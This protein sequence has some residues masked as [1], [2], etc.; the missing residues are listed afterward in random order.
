MNQ[1]GFNLILLIIIIAVVVIGGGAYLYFYYLPDKEVSENTNT[2]V[3]NA[4]VN[5]N[6]NANL[7]VNTNE[8]NNLNTDLSSNCNISL[9]SVLEPLT[10]WN[11][12]WRSD[13][14]YLTT[15][16]SSVNEA[17][18]ACEEKE[19]LSSRNYCFLEIAT[20]FRNPLYCEKINQNVLEEETGSNTNGYQVEDIAYEVGLTTPQEDAIECIENFMKEYGI[21]DCQIHE[22]DQFKDYCYYNAAV[23]VYLP[24]ER[25]L[26][27]CLIK[28]T[29][30][31]ERCV[32]VAEGWTE[33]EEQFGEIEEDLNSLE[34]A[35]NYIIKLTCYAKDH[36]EILN[37]FPA[38]DIR[39][40]IREDSENYTDCEV[41]SSEEIEKLLT[42]VNTD[43]DNDGLN[44]L[45]ESLYLI[46]DTNTDTD[47]DGYD[48]LT[49]VING[50]NPNGEGEL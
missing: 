47:G 11:T 35:Y 7:N 2:L 4:N 6:T 50:Y 8:N 48:D 49:E 31:N 18:E 25:N 28:D 1:K 26:N 22:S 41:L 38:G 40:E 39:E 37:K 17:L 15:I 46:D 20:A 3:N 24:E 29:S 19:H 14:I 34:V 42:Y 30:L 45:L 33:L 21:Y 10:T 36:P 16:P 44:L 5:D 32:E 43:S 23:S 12:E 9:P 13:P 27:C